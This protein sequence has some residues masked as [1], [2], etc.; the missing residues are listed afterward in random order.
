M[1]NGPLP[2]EQPVLDRAPVET[3][4]S[5]DATISSLE[6]DQRALEQVAEEQA[7]TF[8][9]TATEEVAPTTAV[10]IT[11]PAT[12]PASP[13]AQASVEKD[14]VF[15][16]VEKIL[17]DGLGDYYNQLPEP[18]KVRFQ[19]KGEQV[20]GEIAMMV[21]GLKVKVKQVILLIRD[22]LLT[23]PGVNKFFLEQEAKIKTDRILELERERREE[24]SPSS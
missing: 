14:E 10:S 17:E 12:H 6:A 13:P 9:E 16:A 18:A 3:P 11:D 20:A 23:I 15:K 2:P 7:D 4:V 19:Q 21:R 24:S 5:G 1:A 8:L 22:W